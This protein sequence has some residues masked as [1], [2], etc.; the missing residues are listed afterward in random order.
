MSIFFSR[1]LS[2]LRCCY[3]YFCFF[4]HFQIFISLFLHFDTLLSICETYIGKFC[5]SQIGNTEFTV[6][7]LTVANTLSSN[8]ALITQALTGQSYKNFQS[9]TTPNS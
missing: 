9:N 1:S 6:E 7:F 3:V 2:I 8:E 5:F 4:S